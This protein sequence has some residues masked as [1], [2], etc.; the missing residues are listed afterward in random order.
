MVHDKKKCTR[1]LRHVRL[2]PRLSLSSLLKKTELGFE[3]TRLE[4][5]LS[6]SSL[7]RIKRI[8]GLETRS[9]KPRLSLSLSWRSG[10]TAVVLAVV[11]L[12]YSVNK[13]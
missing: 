11:V 9:L 12:L 10:A 6:S 2:E 1:G 8:L 7:W 3:M 4:P 13:Y 5:H